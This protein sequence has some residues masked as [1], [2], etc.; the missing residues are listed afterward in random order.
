MAVRCQ[1]TACTR[2]SGEATNGRLVRD[3]NPRSV[4][5]AATLLCLT[6]CFSTVAVGFCL[7]VGKVVLGAGALSRPLRGGANVGSESSS[8]CWEVKPLCSTTGIVGFVMVGPLRLLLG[9]LF[10]ATARLW[11]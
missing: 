8:S 9:L 6:G 1:D 11:G 5:L 10:A 7:T 4:S 3:T 2:L